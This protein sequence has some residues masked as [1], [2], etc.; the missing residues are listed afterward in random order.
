MSSWQ[1]RRSQRYAT[2]YPRTYEPDSRQ[3]GTW[4]PDTTQKIVVPY[5]G[6]W[7]RSSRAEVPGQLTIEI[8]R[9]IIPY[10]IPGADVW[11]LVELSD[12]PNDQWDITAP[13]Q[14]HW[15]TPT[16]RHMSVDLR[17]RP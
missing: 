8:R 15:G 3:N 14:Y 17:R 10:H 6:W 16:V 12:E 7:V 2:I 13:P 1:R 5:S 11:G 4:I 9:I